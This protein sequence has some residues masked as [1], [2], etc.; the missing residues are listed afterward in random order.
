MHPYLLCTISPG[1]G[2]A[3]TMGDNKQI[4]HDE[5]TRKQYNLLHVDIHIVGKLRSLAIC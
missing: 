4:E 1:A 2:L 3:A 5:E